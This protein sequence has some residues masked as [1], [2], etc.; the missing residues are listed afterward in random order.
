MDTRQELD[1]MDCREEARMYKT[2]PGDG[3]APYHLP[4]Q[5][6]LDAIED[7]ARRLIEADVVL[8][9]AK[10]HVVQIGQWEWSLDSDLNLWREASCYAEHLR[11]SGLLDRVREDGRTEYRRA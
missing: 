4:G 8:F 3:P 10:R 5:D 2:N 9:L 7:V 1:E 6:P 11:E